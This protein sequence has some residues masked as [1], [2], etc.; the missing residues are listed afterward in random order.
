MPDVFI[1][2][3]RGS[4]RILEPLNPT[5]E[6]QAYANTYTVRDRTAMLGRWPPLSITQLQ[7]VLEC[8]YRRPRT[9]HSVSRQFSRR[10][11]ITLAIVAAAARAIATLVGK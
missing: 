11:L 8:G 2:F 6:A 4:R 3:P 10:V 9:V 7:Y 5:L 1:S